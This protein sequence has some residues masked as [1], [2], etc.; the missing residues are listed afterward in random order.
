MSCDFHKN[1]KVT[2]KTLDPMPLL[3]GDYLCNKHIYPN[4]SNTCCFVIPF[5]PFADFTSMTS[6]DLML[7]YIIIFHIFTN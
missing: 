6:S 4:P 1:W 7:A 3:V 2:F 5:M